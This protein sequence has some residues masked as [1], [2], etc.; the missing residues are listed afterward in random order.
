MID[1]HAHILPGVDDGAKDEAMTRE[2]LKKAADTGVDHI[3]CTPHVYAPEDQRRNLKP[4]GRVRQL[5]REFGIV[6]NPGCEL[7]H[8]AFLRMRI[9][10][11]AGFC[12]G[13]TRCVLLEFPYDNL[14]PN[15]EEFLS[16]LADAGY[17]PIVAH[18][19][20]YAFIQRDTHLA[21]EMVMMG[22]EMQLDASGLMSSLLDPERR[23][24]RWMLKNGLVSYIASDAHRPKHYDTFGR[25]QRAFAADLPRTTRL[26]RSLKE[27]REARNRG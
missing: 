3:I 2:M 6:V 13:P 4:L 20:R 25:A 10:D 8:R 5:A 1:M 7:N 12:L 16:G 17:M 23:T 22:C 24:S 18:P 9:E 11:F 21:Q 26:S 27:I 15:W 14:T 19:E